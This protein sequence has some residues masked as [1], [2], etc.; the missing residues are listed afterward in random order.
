MFFCAA[1][2]I[3]ASVVALD[4]IADNQIADLNTAEAGAEAGPPAEAVNA[5][6]AESSLVASGD[7]VL[8]PEGK[9]QSPDNMTEVVF[10]FNETKD[11]FRV[12]SVHYSNPDWGLINFA[13]RAD[14]ACIS[15]MN[16]YYDTENLQGGA[17][18]AGFTAKGTSKGSGFLRVELTYGV[19]IGRP[20]SPEERK[21]GIKPEY[22][23]T[24]YT[25]FYNTR[26]EAPV[27]DVDASV[28]GE[29]PQ[30]GGRSAHDDPVGE[31]L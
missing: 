19:E 7:R 18:E 27:A 29:V 30:L 13:A 26:V 3:G 2:L 20:V 22:N 25:V 12:K 21:N 17:E 15:G 10:A 4:N 31:E 8:I 28:A 1:V 14:P 11:I 16:L 5:A 9:F 6:D 23:S 24:T